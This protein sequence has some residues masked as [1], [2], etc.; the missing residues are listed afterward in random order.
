VA[1]DRLQGLINAFI[2]TGYRLAYLALRTWWFVR[3]SRTN[4][5]AVALWHED[6]V[7]LIRTSYRSRRS[8]PGGFVRP[9]EPSEQAARRELKEELG[10]TLPPGTLRH[11]W[12]G[13]IPFESRQDTIDIWET[14][15]NSAPTPHVAGRKIIWADWVA[16]AEAVKHP[17]LPHVAAYLEQ[18]ADKMKAPRL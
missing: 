5:A 11:A 10:I 15:V 18:A 16:P 3:R 7:L 13:M 6:R 14:R 4:G 17:L 2:R 8:L 1:T 9:G 12:H